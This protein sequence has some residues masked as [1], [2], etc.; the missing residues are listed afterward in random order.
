MAFRRSPV[1]SLG[2]TVAFKC[3]PVISLGPTMAFRRSPSDQPGSYSGVQ[4]TPDDQEASRG[5]SEKKEGHMVVELL[6]KRKARL[7][8]CGNFEKQTV[9]IMISH[10]ASK[11]T[12]D[13]AITDVRNAFLLAPMSTD[14]VYG[15]RFPKVFLLALGLEWM[16]CTEWTELCTAFAVPHVYGEP[17]VTIV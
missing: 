4:T 13:A 12:W 6:Y 10:V 9:R 5:S 17:S 7:V 14:A 15:L 3:S 1:I 8:I 2:P 16:P 11:P